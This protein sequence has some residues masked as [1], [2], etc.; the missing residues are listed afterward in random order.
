MITMESVSV[1]ID[2]L[3]GSSII[4]V[5]DGFIVLPLFRSLHGTILVVLSALKSRKMVP[6]GIE[7]VE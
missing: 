3:A 1:V 5:L 6:H 2:R 7:A 4:A